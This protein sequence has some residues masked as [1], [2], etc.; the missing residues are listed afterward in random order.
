M[1]QLFSFTDEQLD[2]LLIALVSVG[3]PQAGA[4]VEKVARAGQAV[5]AESLVPA[6]R[7][8]SSN[9]AF[10]RSLLEEFEE[11]QEELRQRFD[12][13]M[14]AGFGDA[15]PMAAASLA[16]NLVIRAAF[17]VALQTRIKELA[18]KSAADEG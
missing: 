4:L 3:L 10:L 11:T 17:I 7:V 6:L 8:L 14:A 2:L 16:F 15:Y 18:E 13:I 5:D 12:D 1:D 9:P